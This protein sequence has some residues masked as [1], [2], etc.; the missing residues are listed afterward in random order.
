MKLLPYFL[1]KNRNIQLKSDRDN[2]TT[3]DTAAPDISQELQHLL[4]IAKIDHNDEISAHGKH[5]EPHE[6]VST[7]NHEKI[8]SFLTTLSQKE[9]KL[10]IK[11]ATVLHSKCENIAKHSFDTEAHSSEEIS[12]HKQNAHKLKE[13]IKK[14]AEGIHLTLATTSFSESTP[15]QNERLKNFPPEI[16]YALSISSFI[17]KDLSLWSVGGSAAAALQAENGGDIQPKDIDITSVYKDRDEIIKKLEILKNDNLVFKDES[18]TE[19]GF[20]EEEVTLYGE[21]LK[22]TTFV[23]WPESDKF[24]ELEIFCE[25]ERNGIAQ[26]GVLKNDLTTIDFSHGLNILDKK[27]LTEYYSLCLLYET[28]GDL[29]LNDDKHDDLTIEDLLSEKEKV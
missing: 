7:E 2:L 25:K 26:L 1:N 15:E 21:S 16:Q 6:F 20:K 14:I 4:D 17:F 11:M 18:G 5:V 29:I 27:H 3:T 23:R 22:I 12:Q 13:A 24:V 10:A 28:A 8:S 9:L 19:V